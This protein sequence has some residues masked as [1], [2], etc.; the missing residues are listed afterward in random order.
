MGSSL[1]LTPFGPAVPMASAIVVLVI[2][3]AF[4]LGY[5]FGV[6]IVPALARRPRDRSVS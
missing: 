1:Y 3:A 6:V 5:Y 2:G 4:S